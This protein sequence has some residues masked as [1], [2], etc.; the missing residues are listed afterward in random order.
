[1]TSFRYSGNLILV[2][3]PGGMMSTKNEY[4]INHMTYHATL[5]FIWE[6]LSSF[7]HMADFLSAVSSHPPLPF[8]VIF[9]AWLTFCSFSV[10]VPLFLSQHIEYQIND[11]Y[12]G[13]IFMTKCV[14]YQ[15]QCVLKQLS[16]EVPLYSFFLNESKNLNKPCL[17][18]VKQYSWTLLPIGVTLFYFQKYSR[19]EIVGNFD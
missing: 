18:D 5:C 10:D 12:W 17:D 13:S 19:L 7:P 9:L 8:A 1:M 2:L 11:K 4:Q 3:I 6:G 15:I 16:P 14:K